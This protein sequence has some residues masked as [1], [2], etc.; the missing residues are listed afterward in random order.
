MKTTYITRLFL[1]LLILLT[2]GTTTAFSQNKYDAQLNLIFEAF[3][4]K[5]FQHLNAVLKQNSKKQL[6][7]NSNNLELVVKQICLFPSPESYRVIEDETIGDNQKITV[8]YQYADKVRY[9]YFT[10]DT[11]GNLI[12]AEVVASA[13]LYL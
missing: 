13:T 10:F 4:T 3:V 7:S 12:A 1:A 9:H 6:Q 8:E 5:D 11:K 2:L